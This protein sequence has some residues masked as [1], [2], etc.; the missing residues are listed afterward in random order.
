[1]KFINFR[2]K[3]PS[4]ISIRSFMSFCVICFASS[5]FFVIP[6]VSKIHTFQPLSSKRSYF[7]LSPS[8]KLSTNL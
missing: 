8:T 7:Q 5:R 6:Q 3:R 2:F 4:K 1:M